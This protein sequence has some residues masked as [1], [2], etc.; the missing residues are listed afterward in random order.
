MERGK[1]TVRGRR[2]TV[3]ANLPRIITERVA[4]GRPGYEWLARYEPHEPNEYGW[5]V[6]EA[7]AVLSL[8]DDRPRGTQCTRDRPF[9]SAATAEAARAR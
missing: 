8:I 7:D 2:L 6:T 4:G 9:L 5:G 1:F 3:P